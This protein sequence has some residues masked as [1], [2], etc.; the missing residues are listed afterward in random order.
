MRKQQIQID[1][2]SKTQ[3]T[4]IP[5]K[6]RGHE[7]QGKTEERSQMGNIMTEDKRGPQIGFLSSQGTSVEN[8]E[9]L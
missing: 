8:L 4:S 7:R 5:P 3:L 1:E 2:Y 9:I 6:C